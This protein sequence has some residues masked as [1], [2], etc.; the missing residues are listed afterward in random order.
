M[1]KGAKLEDS[2][3]TDPKTH[4]QIRISTTTRLIYRKLYPQELR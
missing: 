3:I 4:R 2:E 1:F